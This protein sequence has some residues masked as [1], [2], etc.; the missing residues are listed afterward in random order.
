MGRDREGLCN[1]SLSRF[2]QDLAV[3]PSIASVSQSVKH[4][5][6]VNHGEVLQGE[7][8]IFNQWEV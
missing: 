8:R 4:A 7:A 2:S 6:V 3:Y 5:N 1:R